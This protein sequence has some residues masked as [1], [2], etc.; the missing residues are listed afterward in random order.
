MCIDAGQLI[1]PFCYKQCVSISVM[2]AHELH[3][4]WCSLLVM[5]FIGISQTDKD[6]TWSSVQSINNLLLLSIAVI[7]QFA[8]NMQAYPT[9]IVVR[10]T[11]IIY[12]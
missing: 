6:L 3:E 11:S 4:A 12:M 2:L 1:K 9:D 10:V 8:M 5:K 7:E